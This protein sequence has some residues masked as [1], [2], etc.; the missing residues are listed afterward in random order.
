MGET[1]LLVYFPSKDLNIQWIEVY[2]KKMMMLVCVFV[3]GGGVGGW[4]QKKT[5]AYS[6][7]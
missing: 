5:V 2:E 6:H 4:L 7:A 3:S 1:L